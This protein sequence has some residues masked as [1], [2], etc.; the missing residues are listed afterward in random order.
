MN[1]DDAKKRIEKLRVEINRDRYAYH[2]LG[3]SL[4]PDE[5]LDSLKKELFDL[6]QKFPDLITSDSPT[7]R[8][9]GKPLKE[10]KKIRHGEPM[11][12]FND[13]FSEEDMRAWLARLE[14]YV[15]RPNVSRIK[16]NVSRIFDAHSRP[17]GK[18]SGVAP[19]Y[20]EL[21]IDGLAI[22]LIYENGIFVRGATRGDGKIG[23]DITQNLRT[24]DAIPLKLLEPEEVAN[25]LKKLGLNPK[26]YILNPKHFVVRGEAFLT[27]KEFNL[28]NKEQMKKGLKPYANPR[29]IAAGSIRQLNP[30]ITASRHLDSFEYDIITD[31]GQKFHEEEH[32][33]LGAFGFKT[34]PNNR[35]AKTLKNVFEF[36]DYWA[37]HREKLDYEIDGVVVIVNDNKTFDAGAVIGKAPRAAIAYKFSPREATTIVENIAVKNVFLIGF[38]IWRQKKE[39]SSGKN[40]SILGASVNAL[41][42]GSS[43]G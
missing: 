14:N 3:K 13:A 29:N 39:S 37:K 30:K 2:V 6:E 33:L 25:N 16:A 11:L 31:I 20:C 42:S 1:K 34:N 17:F 28:I 43:Y 4:I 8:V 21:K 35:S 10:F 19:F 32:L 36:R 23:E 22:E 12:S 40:C 7:Q 15:S 41:Q 27:K 38:L 9:A 5:A 18:H 26:S 24:I